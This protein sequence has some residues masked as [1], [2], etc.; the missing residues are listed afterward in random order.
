MTSGD[1]PRDF[2]ELIYKSSH[3]VNA[4]QNYLKYA[5]LIIMLISFAGF[6]IVFQYTYRR[7][8]SPP[9]VD[10]RYA[11]DSVQVVLRDD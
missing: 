6:I 9:V 3:S 10:V 7:P 4:V 11:Q 8:K 2:Q 5:T 1:I